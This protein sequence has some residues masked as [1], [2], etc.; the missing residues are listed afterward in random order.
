MLH[1]V[2]AYDGISYIW[3]K[4]P[5]IIPHPSV[6]EVNKMTTFCYDVMVLQYIACSTYNIMLIFFYKAFNFSYRLCFGACTRCASKRN[7][8]VLCLC[9]YYFTSYDMQG[10]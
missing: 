7:L 8:P 1:L 2:I 4:S 5:N 10:I 6:E 3:T 9:L